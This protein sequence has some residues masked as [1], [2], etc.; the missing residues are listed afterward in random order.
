MNKSK[1]VFMREGIEE[2][3]NKK[4]VGCN[5]PLNM[6]EEEECWHEEGYNCICKCHLKP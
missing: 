2:W 6:K 1:V 4:S 5:S 3:I